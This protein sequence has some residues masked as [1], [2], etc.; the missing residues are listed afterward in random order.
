[1][2]SKNSLPIS[3]TMTVMVIVV[4]LVPS[5]LLDP[6][7]DFKA[8]FLKKCNEFP[9]DPKICEDKF[10]IFE[11]AY[12]GIEESDIT[13]DSYNDLFKITPFKHPCEKTMFYSGTHDLATGFT[14]NRK[15]F[16]SV[17]D[18]LLGHALAGKEWCGKIG[19]KETF[20]ED[21]CTGNAR[22]QF[23][24][25][26]SVEFA[27][28]TCKDLHVM[29]DGTPHPFFPGTALA[30]EEIPYLHHPKV[31]SLTVILVVDKKTP[32]E[33][34]CNNESLNELKEFMTEEKIPYDCKEVTRAHIEKLTEQGTGNIFE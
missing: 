5:A 34:K 19:S 2:A 4:V 10:K 31:E 25:K 29:L 32:G 13:R 18:T 22:L 14:K 24:L 9:E 7:A 28:H 20:L 23:W 17:E 6:T 16:F 8:D 21:E 33:D 3:G 12:V 1:M 30:E 15:D 27:K 26:M 11:K